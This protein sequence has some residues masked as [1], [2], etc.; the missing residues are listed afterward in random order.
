M[1]SADK[2]CGRRITTPTPTLPR[3]PGGELRQVILENVPN[4][5]RRDGEQNTDWPAA[6]FPLEAW[7]GA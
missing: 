2:R 5:V 1:L 4:R 7:F 3:E 6:C